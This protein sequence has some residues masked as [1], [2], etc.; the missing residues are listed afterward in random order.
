MTLPL[1]GPMSLSGFDHS[2]FFL[3]LLVVLG[4]AAMS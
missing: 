2:W 1:L 4:L 3:F